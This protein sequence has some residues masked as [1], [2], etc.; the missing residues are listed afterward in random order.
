[1]LRYG[2]LAFDCSLPP[3]SAAGAGA[4]AGGSGSGSGSGAGSSSE[5]GSPRLR[6]GSS[7]R[8]GVPA[9][10]LALFNTRGFEQPEKH[11]ML[12]PKGAAYL[13]ALTGEAAALSEQG[14]AWG[15]QLASEQEQLQA[16]SSEAL[17]GM[18]GLGMPVVLRK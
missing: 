6:C 4:G 18:A 17:R 12:T 11:A 8:S 2:M 14:L 16:L 5:A 13:E 1:M 10:F 3:P 7:P 9:P 15:L